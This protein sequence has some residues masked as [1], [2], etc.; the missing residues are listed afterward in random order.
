M[1][2]S[3]YSLEMRLCTEPVGTAMRGSPLELRKGD[4]SSS[5]MAR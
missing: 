4:N 2:L 5:K 1:P 3:K